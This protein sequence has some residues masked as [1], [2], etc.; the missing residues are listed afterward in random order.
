MVQPLVCMEQTNTINNRETNKLY[1]PIKNNDSQRRSFIQAHSTKNRWHTGNH[2]YRDRHRSWR[3][4][5]SGASGISLSKMCLDFQVKM[6]S[7]KRKC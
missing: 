5:L 7:R 6:V 1:G 3:S 4:K 2:H